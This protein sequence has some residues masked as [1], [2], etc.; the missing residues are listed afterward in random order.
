MAWKWWARTK[1]IV[2]PIGMAILFILEPF[3]ALATQS[4]GSAVVWMGEM[5]V[6]VAA[7]LAIVRFAP[8]SSAP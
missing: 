2:V 7:V 8:K 5:A 6:G 1:S 4:S 3:A